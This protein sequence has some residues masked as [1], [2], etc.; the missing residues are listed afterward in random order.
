VRGRRP[1]AKPVINFDNED[2]NSMTIP[3]LDREIL[4]AFWKAHILHHA[5]R[6]GVVGQWMILEL[7]RHG[8]EISPGT[9]YPMLARMVRRGWL[10]VTHQDD[11]KHGPRTY[12][13]TEDG[14]AVLE[15]L[16]EQ[17][18]ELYREVVLGE[19]DDLKEP[20]GSA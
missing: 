9:L 4:L 5:E 14:R 16:R 1:L 7:R 13:I 10:S 8:Y 3:G 11:M 12:G 2:R 15:V 20:H 17:I 6:E 19:E 18:T